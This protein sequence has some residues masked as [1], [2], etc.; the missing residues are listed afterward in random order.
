MVKLDSLKIKVNRDCVLKRNEAV[1]SNSKKILSDGLIAKDSYSLDTSIKD[2]LGI[3]GLKNIT[4]NSTLNEKG[5][6]DVYIELSGKIAPNYYDLINQNNIEEIITKLN[7]YELVKLDINKFLDSAEI[8]NCDVT[9]NT[10]PTFLFNDCFQVLECYGINQ[11]YQAKRYTNESIVFKKTGKGASTNE[12]LIIY[13]KYRELAL[14]RNKTFKKYLEN[15][16]GIGKYKGV[17]RIETNLRTLKN[18]RTAFQVKDRMLTEILTSPENVNLK[19]FSKIVV[20]DN[21]LL[22][23]VDKYDKNISIGQLHTLEGMTNIIRQLNFDEKKIRHLLTQHK[24]HNSDVTRHLNNYRKLMAE[25]K[26]KDIVK[27]ENAV[28]TEIKKM[29]E[30]A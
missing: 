14:Y 18:I 10:H 22:N 29:L 6:Y 2:R 4:L 16:T 3:H 5:S 12:R 9:T 28:I 11:K 30:V 7:N 20:D 13:D 27:K 17:L 25:M 24:N 19:M 23:L 15:T 26:G 8:L 1:F 21:N